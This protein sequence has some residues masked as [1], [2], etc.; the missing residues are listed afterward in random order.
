M[1]KWSDGAPFALGAAMRAF[2]LVE[3]LITVAIIAILAA[4]A[5]PNFLE[6]QAR[7]KV[8]RELADMR[9]LA[10]GLE[11]Y[12]ADHNGYPPHGEVLG[13]GTVN[14]P[15]T[16][17]GIATVEYVPDRPLTTPVAYLTSAFEDVCLPRSLP[18]LLRRYGYVQTNQMAAIMVARGWGDS[19]ATLAPRFGGWR[20]YAAGPD[21]DKGPDAKLTIPYDATNGTI[22][23]GDIVRSQKHPL[24]TQFVDEI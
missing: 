6:S 24:D 5:V 23:N 8:S 17:A 16:L 13:N 10:V 2:T 9:T 15:A 7:T 22:S 11:A 18:P 19:A 3:L 14:F 12:A 1:I 21:G 4:V 20:L